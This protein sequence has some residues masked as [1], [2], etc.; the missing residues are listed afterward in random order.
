MTASIAPTRSKPYAGELWYGV[1]GR[2]VRDRAYVDPAGVLT[3]LGG[4]RPPAVHMSYPG[5][6]GPF[7]AMVDPEGR[8]DPWQVA[9]ANTLIPYLVAFEPPAV[10]RRI[11]RNAR[12]QA[13]EVPTCRVAPRLARALT[14]G[15]LRFCVECQ[16]WELEAHGECFWHCVH[17]L[18]G[19][20]VCP[21]HWCGLY[22][23]C[24]SFCPER[25]T[26]L[27]PHASRCIAQPDSQCRAHVSR[28][29]QAAI[30]LGSVEAMRD[31]LSGQLY[32][33]RPAYARHLRAA[34]FAGTRG[35]VAT[36]A[37]DDAFSEFLSRHEA[38][39]QTFGPEGWWRATYTRVPASVSPL[40][41]I[42]MRVFV[43]AAKR[44]PPTI[45]AGASG[46]LVE[47]VVAWAH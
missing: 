43:Q 29:L 27:P 5:R 16:R 45:R 34:G 25:L 30:Q 33:P 7:A 15:Y 22:E 6:L 39:A 8:A 3:S 46:R 37:L 9:E 21:K 41:H 11:Q 19:L 26:F 24:V 4:R 12:A 2:R 42:V 35:R 36:T 10:T 31:G 47:Q 38:P 32:L 40:Q 20:V 18:P 14:P 23:S 1:V 13:K 44:R 17:Q 28:R